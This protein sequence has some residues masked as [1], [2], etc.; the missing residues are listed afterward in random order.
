MAYKK[1]VIG[2]KKIYTLSVMGALAVCAVVGGSLINSE[3]QATKSP[4]GEVTTAYVSKLDTNSN[5]LNSDNSEKLNLANSNSI[6]SNLNTDESKS[7]ESKSDESKSNESKSNE[8]KSNESKLKES[9]PK[10]QITEVKDK[11]NA[12]ANSISSVGVDQAKITGLNF[13]EKSNFIWPVEGEVIIDYD[14][15]NVVYFKTLDVYKCSD[16][17]CVSS[18]KDTPVYAGA[19]GVVTDIGEDARIGKYV[20]MNLGNNYEVIYG[21]LK[22]VQVSSGLTVVKGDLVGYI[23]NP[24]KYYAL[25]G[26]NLYIQFFH[27][28][29][30]I[31]P[32][33]F[34]SVE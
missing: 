29:K 3:P 33:T 21:Q 13:G 12:D 9:D 14:M 4:S 23:N 17:M 1:S 7:N 24:T 20:K 16:A 25:E 10:S 15:E 26:D 18:K 28:G 27:E 32:Q 30:A 6:N 2:D 19:K 8:S 11:E 31:D 34:L 5:K 22:D